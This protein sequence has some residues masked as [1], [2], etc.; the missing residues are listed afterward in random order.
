M[1]AGVLAQAV[2][3][4][5]VRAA[6]PTASTSSADLGQ[7][8]SISHDLTFTPFQQSGN[9]PMPRQPRGSAPL[10][11][12]TMSTPNPNQQP[13]N[14]QTSGS[15]WPI[16]RQNSGSLPAVKKQTEGQ[17]AP[18]LPI[19]P[20]PMFPSPSSL[21]PQRDPG[22][23]MDGP[24]STND[25]TMRPAF[26]KNALRKVSSARDP[27]AGQAHAQSRMLNRRFPPAML[28]PLLEQCRRRGLAHRRNRCQTTFDRKCLAR[29][30]NP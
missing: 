4:F 21:I 2:D 27:E 3:G 25:A 7:R 24:L 8:G 29:K 28:R 14:T 9:G 18:P 26:E 23:H 30:R 16:S 20:R 1:P 13:A 22:V 12:P 15:N 19:T 5:R 11:G 17:S 10:G 6:S